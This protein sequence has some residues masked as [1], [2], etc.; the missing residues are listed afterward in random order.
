M[1][2][3]VEINEYISKILL[4]D[5]WGVHLELE[6]FSDFIISKFKYLT[7][8]DHECQSHKF[9]LQKEKIWQACYFLKIVM[10]PWPQKSIKMIII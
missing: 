6:A 1:E 2:Y 3:E 7:H 8:L 5:E 10:I 4:N 9:K